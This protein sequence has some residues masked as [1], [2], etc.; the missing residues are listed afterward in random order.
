MPFLRTHYARALSNGFDVG[1]STPP[2]FST[3]T[4]TCAPG[5]TCRCNVNVLP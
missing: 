4:I 1:A 2:A 5:A 3:V